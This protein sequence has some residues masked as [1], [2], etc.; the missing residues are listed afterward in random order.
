MNNIG[1]GI[2]AQ[3]LNTDLTKYHF[4]GRVDKPQSKTVTMQNKVTETERERKCWQ[5]QLSLREPASGE[6]D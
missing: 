2:I 5:R 6:E 3:I 1:I 4:I